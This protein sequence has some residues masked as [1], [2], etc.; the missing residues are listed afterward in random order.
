MDDIITQFNDVLF[1]AGLMAGSWTNITDLLVDSKFPVHQAVGG[2]IT[3]EENVFHSDIK[4]FFGAATV[5]I[6]TMLLILPAYWGRF[7][8]EYNLFSRE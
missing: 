3:R 7:S 8:Q 1:R 2:T 5:Q 4:W 6:L